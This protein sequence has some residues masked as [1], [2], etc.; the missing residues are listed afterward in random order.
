MPAERSVSDGSRARRDNLPRARGTAP[1]STS[2]FAWS[3]SGI[4]SEVCLDDLVTGLAIGF[5]E[6]V[7]LIVVGWVLLKVVGGWMIYLSARV[8]DLFGL[9]N[10]H[11]D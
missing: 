5:V 8:A 6:D 9:V 1:P 3:T 2:G 4:C 7:A 10:N 11:R